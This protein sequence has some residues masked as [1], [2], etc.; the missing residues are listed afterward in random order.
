[1]EIHQAV[2]DMLRIVD[3]LQDAYPKKKFT[4]DGRLVGDMGEILVEKDYEIQLYDSLKKHYDGEPPDG[5]KVQIKTTMK[6]SLTFPADHIPSYYIGIK[7]HHDGQYT[8]I[9]NGP[10][11]VAREALKNRKST[12]T[13]L[14]S[15]AL[16]TLQKSTKKSLK[17]TE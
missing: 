3:T 11:S 16:S 14:H 9:F 4:L 10:G 1:M 15:I 6:E 2:K 13:N 8:E 12:K 7:V 5:R 17:K